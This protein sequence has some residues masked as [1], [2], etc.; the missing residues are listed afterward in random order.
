MKTTLINRLGLIFFV[1][2]GIGLLATAGALGVH[3][4][5]SSKSNLD[6]PQN[7]V[8]IKGSDHNSIS[9]D[10]NSQHSISLLAD[11][12]VTSIRFHEVTSRFRRLLVLDDLLSQLEPSE[13]R[14]LHLT[15][16]NTERGSL[17]MEIQSAIFHHLALV[18]PASA[19]SHID[20]SLS[21][22]DQNELMGVVFQE[23]SISNL[24]EAVGRAKLLNEKQR[25]VAFQGIQESRVDLTENDLHV[26]AQEL[27]IEQAFSDQIALSLLD[28]T[29]EDPSGRWNSLVLQFGSD[30][31]RWNDAQRQVLANVAKSW[32]EQEKINAYQAI[33][34]DLTLRE[35]R[36]WLV[37]EVLQQLSL[38]HLD[39][40][41]AI[42]EHMLQSDYLGLVQVIETW[43]HEDGNAALKLAAHID[44]ESGN[45]RM[46]RAAIKAWAES[47]PA[48]VLDVTVELPPVLRT[49]SLQT[50]LLEMGKI[51]PKAVPKLIDKV[52]NLRSK[53]IVVKNLALNWSKLDPFD[54]LQWVITDPVVAQ[55][56]GSPERGVLNAAVNAS[57]H[58]ALRAA[59]DL[60]TNEFGVGPEA[61]VIGA[62]ADRDI[63]RALDMLD[64]ARNT[65]TSLSAHVGIA[66][67][68]IG[69]GKSEKAFAMIEPK[70]KDFQDSFFRYLAPSWARIAPKDLQK[71]LDRMPTEETKEFCILELL[72]HNA[73]SPFLTVEEVQELKALVP[74]NVHDL[75][76]HSTD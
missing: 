9:V 14:E 13:L 11:D 74:E 65:E 52:T 61:I 59:L 57:P 46:Q 63:D 75:H 6:N 16:E 43:A 49:W 47:E 27:D 35:S 73:A 56:P 34:S 15:I 68:L 31:Q 50:A 53:E 20:S 64:E 28:Q 42:G 7:A 10:Q 1:G 39:L 51:N 3:Y 23:W 22:D 71:K 70:S 36:V 19:L 38:T 4:I 72:K 32:I 55:L 8:S 45:M 26:I 54:A 21:I 5:L 76:K 60:P 12:N 25:Q 24:N 67:T 18:N 33:V 62:M 40:V 29:V 66:Q 58:R 41:H 2:V 17:R 30:F 69:H 48:S 44:D 37:G